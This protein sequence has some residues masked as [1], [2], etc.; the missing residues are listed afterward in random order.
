MSQKA[1]KLFLD[2]LSQIA[3]VNQEILLNKNDPKYIPE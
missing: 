2:K 1:C 3:E